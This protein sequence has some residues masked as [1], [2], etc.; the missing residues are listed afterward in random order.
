MQDKE[1]MENILLNLKGECD[2]LMHAT[3]ESSTPNVHAA[4]KS[5]LDET[6]AMQ[7]EVYAK[8]AAQGWYPQTPA[9]Q[10][11]IDAVKQKFSAGC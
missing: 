7:S 5:A 10:K 6:L 3:V 9:E 11:Q 1:I 4:F 8:M 2:L